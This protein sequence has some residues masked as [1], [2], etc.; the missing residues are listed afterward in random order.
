VRDADPAER[1]R[2]IAQRKAEGSKRLAEAAQ[3]IRAA[4]GRPALSTT[5]TS[6]APQV[7]AL[8]AINDPDVV[9][10]GLAEIAEAIEAAADKAR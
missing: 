2:L 4:A 10:V 6:L 7:R 3:A 5:L 1:E 8:I 9:R